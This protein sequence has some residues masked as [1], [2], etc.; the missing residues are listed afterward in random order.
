[1]PELAETARFAKDLNKL[2]AESHL[3]GVK[4]NIE[5]KFSSK[6]A[7]SDA[8]NEVMKNIGQNTRFMSLGKCLFLTLPR[9]NQVLNIKLGMS[10]NFQTTVKS[11]FE[12]HI[13]WTF[14]FSNGNV[15]HFVDPRRFGS[16]T[17]HR[18]AEEKVR[19]LALGGYNGKQFIIRELPRIHR[20]MTQKM[21]L[22]KT[23]R[24]TWLLNTGKYTGI[25][26]Y[27]ANEALGKLDLNP[28][29]PFK[30]FKEITAV[31]KQCQDVAAE[32]Y[33]KGGYSFGGGYF[34][35]NGEA[36]SFEGKFYQAIEKQMFR[37]RPVYTRYKI[38][39]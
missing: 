7:P 2:I 10:G 8:V 27:M 11:G 3:V 19:E 21:Q 35:L 26:N 32:S 28:F 5:D 30:N 39:Q 34:L 20:Y 31:F 16:V 36:G 12:K 13:F 17:L 37:N 1:M 29:Q 9:L 4:A 25:G 22:P 24:I 14:K 6:L 18:G 33:S 23:P 15:A 38:E